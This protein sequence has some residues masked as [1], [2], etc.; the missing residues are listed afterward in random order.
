[1]STVGTG[2]HRLFASL[3]TPPTF[4]APRCEVLFL[5]MDPI[6]QVRT[7]EFAVQRFS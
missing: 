5:S 2:S 3:S 6:P 1:M 7:A 4:S